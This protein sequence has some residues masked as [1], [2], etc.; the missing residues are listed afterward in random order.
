MYIA[1]DE[2]LNQFKELEVDLL[3]SKTTWAMNNLDNWNYELYV[4]VNIYAGDN[5]WLFSISI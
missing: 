2:L 3:I 5:D 4:D 1:L